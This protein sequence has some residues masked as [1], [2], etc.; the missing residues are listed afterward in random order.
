M[1]LLCI[2]ILTAKCAAKKQK[3][4]EKYIRSLHEM[5]WC[6]FRHSKNSLVCT[7]RYEAAGVLIGRS[8]V[9]V[10]LIVPH[11][12][13]GLPAP[14]ARVD[15]HRVD[16]PVLHLLHDANVV[17]YTVLR[18]GISSLKWLQRGYIWRRSRDSGSSLGFIKKSRW[19]M[20]TPI[21]SSALHLCVWLFG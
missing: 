12:I 18:P 10:N 17:G 2:T 11:G 9:P 4:F 3:I 13:V 21:S 1:P 7:R 5:Q 19:I 15:L 8:S 6:K 20:G 16:N 14:V